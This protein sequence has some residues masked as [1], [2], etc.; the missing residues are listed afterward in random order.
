MSMIVCQHTNVLLRFFFAISSVQ[1][2]KQR[3]NEKTSRFNIPVKET[4][5]TLQDEFLSSVPGKDLSHSL[6]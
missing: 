5:K 6:Y 1:S 3:I 4:G 2:Q